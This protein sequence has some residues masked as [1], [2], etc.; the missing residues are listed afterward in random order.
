[1]GVM[2][3]VLLKLVKLAPVCDPSIPALAV[4]AGLCHYRSCFQLCFL[5]SGTAHKS[6]TL[7]HYNTPNTTTKRHKQQRT[8]HDAPC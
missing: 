3:F 6:L 8:Q 7:L 4:A 2:L 1:M 5:L